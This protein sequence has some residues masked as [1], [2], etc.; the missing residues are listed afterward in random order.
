MLAPARPRF[1]TA[2][3]LSVICSLLATLSLGLSEAR[4]ERIVADM[5]D[6]VIKITS[7]FTGS[8]IVVFGM[9]ERD[10]FTVSRGDPY[11]LIITVRGR[12]QTLVSRRKDR[13]AGIWINNERHFFQNAPNFFVVTSTR[14]LE[15]ITSP[16]T[17]FNLQLGSNYLLMPPEYS[18]T[19][20]FPSYNPFR[21]AAL[22]LKREE[23]LYR[24]E[25]STI[26]F[27][28]DS[29]FRSTVD[30]PANVEVGKYEVTVHLFRGGALLHSASQPLNIAKS[31]F[32]QMAFG[33]SRNHSMIYGMI[34]VVIALFMGW[35]AG[36]VF[37][38]N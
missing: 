12:D 18:P 13:V 16:D 37:R 25:L 33:M 24:D 11:D 7:N 2:L 19:R 5:S 1:G 15:D 30:L 6:R 4:A 14:R 38:R 17:L 27:L 8:N 32:E 10:A 20:E 23:G 36:V 26:T 21:E 9:I 22:R 3:W 35:F 29:M 28:N 34:C 31:G